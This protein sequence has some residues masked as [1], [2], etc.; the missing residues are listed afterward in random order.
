MRP[1]P[2]LVFAAAVLG[3]SLGAFADPPSE[4]PA[5]PTPAPAVLA[6]PRV[7]APIVRTSLVERDETGKVRRL[8]VPPAEAGVGLLAL[9]DATRAGVREVLD[10]RAASLDRVVR[11]NLSLL[12]KIA[13]AGQAGDRA[14]ARRLLRDLYEK[15]EPLR[16]QGRL[17]DELRAVLPAERA[18]ELKRL[19]DE[20]TKAVFAEAQAA[21]DADDAARSEVGERAG[22]RADRG[23]SLRRAAQGEMIAA[24]GRELKR[25]YE[26]V[27]TVSVKDF[28]ELLKKLELRPEQE[29]EVRRL[30]TDQFQRTEGKPTPAQ[31]GE[32]FAKIYAE[33]DAGQR[34]KLLDEVRGRGSK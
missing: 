26:R 16:A 28:D 8:D 18:D 22:V 3:T 4:I 11:E 21:L 10:R 19:V 29:A 25:S 1:R 30:V 12:V 14:E 2:A 13:T 27:V 5:P 6:G 9:D 24:V 31:R 23:G 17:L 20:Y 32:L 34:G 15:A 7:D 33:L